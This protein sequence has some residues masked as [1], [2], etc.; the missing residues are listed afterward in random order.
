MTAT[1]IDDTLFA[2]GSAKIIDTGQAS[3][4]LQAIKTMLVKNI[5]GTVTSETAN[6][7]TGGSQ[8]MALGAADTAENGHQPKMLFAHLYS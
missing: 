6:V 1:E 5:N 7:V 8:M 2:I 4:A 3:A